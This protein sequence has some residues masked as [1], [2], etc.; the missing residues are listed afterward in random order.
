MFRQ[1]VIRQKAVLGK[2]GGWVLVGMRHTS[3]S[4]MHGRYTQI[5]MRLVTTVHTSVVQKGGPVD[6]HHA[7]APQKLDGA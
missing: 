6:I 4:R 5:Q 3:V 7:V 2:Q 1:H